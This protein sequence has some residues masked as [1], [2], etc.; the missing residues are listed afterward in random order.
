MDTVFRALGDATRL[1]ILGLLSQKELCVCQIAEALGI[2][3]PSASKHLG[4]LR[5][6]GIITCK[7]VSQWCF[8]YVPDTFKT[9]HDALWACLCAV[10]LR[11]A[12]YTDDAA[13]LQSVIDSRIC[14]QQVLK[15]N[16]ES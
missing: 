11:D 8:Y 12:P 6:A 14:C 10:F 16:Q 13:M 4:K 5:T 15:K 2:S 9:R 1:R 7:K 3:Q